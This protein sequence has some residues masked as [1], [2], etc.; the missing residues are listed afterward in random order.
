MKWSMGPAMGGVPRA[1]EA[2]YDHTCNQCKCG[3]RYAPRIETE[4]SIS[5]S[6]SPQSLQSPA[7][8]FRENWAECLD[9]LTALTF[10]S[11]CK[12][13]EGW[14][15]A[16]D[17]VSQL[18]QTSCVNQNRGVKIRCFEGKNGIFVAHVIKDDVPPC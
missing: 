10:S 5:K 17:A 7:W 18:Y 8:H 11:C 4:S 1:S 12:D 16:P 14:Q 2:G 6:P 13:L 15:W 9:W 3:E